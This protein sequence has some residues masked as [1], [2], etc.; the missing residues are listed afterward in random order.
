MKSKAPS[1]PQAGRQSVSH[2]FPERQRPLRPSSPRMG[3][4]QREIFA[5]DFPCNCCRR[6]ALYSAPKSKPVSHTGQ[7]T[8]C[9]RTWSFCFGSQHSPFIQSRRVPPAL[10]PVWHDAIKS[11]CYPLQCTAPEALALNIQPKELLHL[12]KNPRLLF[13]LSPLPSAWGFM[14]TSFAS[15][16]PLQGGWR[17]P[18]LRRV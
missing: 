2:C 9:A 3:R 7:S 12:G 14:G 6:D 16:C 4:E 15:H 1:C 18:L 8:G 11:L 13:Q 17:L 5:L 10:T